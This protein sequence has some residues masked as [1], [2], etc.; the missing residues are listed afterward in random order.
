MTFVACVT[1]V[2]ALT[3]AKMP[4]E[5]DPTMAGH[6]RHE[7]ATRVPLFLQRRWT[8]EF[9]IVYALFGSAELCLFS[10]CT[11]WTRR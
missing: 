8:T 10:I 6:C 3:V 7:R 4:L 9:A 2:I 11:L 1:L 5:I